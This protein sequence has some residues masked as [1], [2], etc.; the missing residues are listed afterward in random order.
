MKL[1]DGSVVGQQIGLYYCE[2]IPH[3]NLL[4]LRFHLSV[5][6]H[7]CRFTSSLNAY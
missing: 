7:Q 2:I 6:E 1:L 3:R 4:I 5:S